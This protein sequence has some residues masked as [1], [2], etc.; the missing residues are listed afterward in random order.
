MNKKGLSKLIIILIVLILIVSFLIFITL[1]KVKFQKEKQVIIEQS[2]INSEIINITNF[3]FFYVKGN[4]II[5]LKG[6][7]IKLRGFNYDSFYVI[8]KKIYFAKK[9]FKKVDENNIEIAKYFFNEDDIKNF[10]NIGA[11]VVRLEIRLWEIEKKPYVY[12]EESLKQLDYTIKKFGE[13]DI[14]VILDLH[15]AGQNTLNHNDEYGNI[16]WDNTDDIWNRTVALWGI[17]SERYKNNNYIVGY[18]LINEPEAPNK[19]ILHTFYQDVINK[20]REK[21]K[22]HILFIELNL[23]KKEKI[24]IGGKY[25][26]NNLAVSMHFYKPNEFTT[27]GMKKSSGKKYPNTY[28][29]VYW[30]KNEINKYFDKFLNFEELKGKPMFIGEFGANVGDG[31][32]DSLNWIDDVTTILNKKGLHYTFFSYKLSFTPSL[33]YYYADKQ[34]EFKITEL[35]NN[36]LRGLDFKDVTENKKRYFLTNNYNHSQELNQ[37]LERKFKF[38]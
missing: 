21:D 36:L 31:G 12:S 26:D 28:K 15:A 34:L 8:N 18:D 2:K 6:N 32:K 23:Y 33:G 4:K 5:D 30:D 7:E 13:N 17:I 11:N 3:S 24:L 10:K 20:I 27:Q 14:Y 29:G 38:S 16:L 1:I 35:V 22:K 25:D 19:R 37:I 9:D